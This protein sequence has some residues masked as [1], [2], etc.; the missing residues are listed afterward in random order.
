MHLAANFER[1]REGGV[2]THLHIRVISFI[3]SFYIIKTIISLT[4]LQPSLLFT[5]VIH[6]YDVF[7][8]ISIFITSMCI[9]LLKLNH[10]CQVINVISFQT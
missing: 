10:F 6:Y 7:I 5:I 8:I 4:A 3:K 1:G 2:P 9:K